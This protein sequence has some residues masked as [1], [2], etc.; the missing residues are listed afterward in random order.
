M[1]LPIAFSPLGADVLVMSAV[2]EPTTLFAIGATASRYLSAMRLATRST[3]D[4]S[5]FSTT[6]FAARV[7]T[8]RPL[9]SST[10]RE[11]SVTTRPSEPALV[12]RVLRPA[13]LGIL[14]LYHWWVWPLITARYSARSFATIGT[15]A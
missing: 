15:T 2:T 6:T 12:T 8:I 10:T 9:A 3:N 4:A 1:V 11:T 5:L 14:Q 13:A 7:R